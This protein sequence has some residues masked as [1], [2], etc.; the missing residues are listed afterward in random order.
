MKLPLQ[1]V[2]IILEELS[3]E[4]SFI[5]WPSDFLHQAS[6][7]SKQI[8]NPEVIKVAREILQHVQKLN[9]NMNY[10][11]FA[12]QQRR[13]LQR[14]YIKNQF[15][16]LLQE[17]QVQMKSRVAR[18]KARAFHIT[19]VQ[20]RFNMVYRHFEDSYKSF[21]CELSKAFIKLY[22]EMFT[23]NNLYSME[24][25]GVAK[26]SYA[27][28]HNLLTTVKELENFTACLSYT[29]IKMCF[30]KF[31]MNRN[32]NGL[33]TYKISLF[34]T[35][36]KMNY[37]KDKYLPEILYDYLEISHATKTIINDS[38][39]YKKQEVSDLCK[40]MNVEDCKKNATHLIEYLLS[41][42]IEHYLKKNNDLWNTQLDKTGF[43][44]TLKNMFQPEENRLHHALLIKCHRK[45][46]IPMIDFDD[47]IDDYVLRDIE[48][49]NGNTKMS[50]IPED[51]WIESRFD[52][53]L[54]PNRVKDDML[55]KYD[56]SLRRLA[57]LKEK[58]LLYDLHIDTNSKVCK[59]YIW[60]IF[61]Y[62][63]D[64]DGVI[65]TLFYYQKTKY[66]KYMKVAMHMED[67][68]ELVEELCKLAAL[69]T[70]FEDKKN[71][72]STLIGWNSEKTEAAYEFVKIKAIEYADSHITYE[73]DSDVIDT[74]SS[75]EYEGSDS[76]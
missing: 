49:A 39:K 74:E 12:R 33:E 8:D 4:I 42:D 62:I 66:S 73:Y 58:I 59:Q 7:I 47:D 76:D 43:D 3:K 31:V 22:V 51:W 16:I 40:F 57:L 61:D 69:H 54:W 75:E 10:K 11:L 38:T 32:E 67:D 71:I 9:P 36:F 13:M 64:I 28:I 26:P 15:D 34:E 46:L 25:W 55:D 41:D 44:A 20:W 65:E 53:P 23:H 2:H 17:Q 5:F 6:I 30:D 27:I 18:Q 52:T 56:V 1:I 21:S 37:I 72:P 60:K 24:E 29:D 14:K 63:D 70:Y 45:G 19:T 50:E 48:Y 35:D 68:F